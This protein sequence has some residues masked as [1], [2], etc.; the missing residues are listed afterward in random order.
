MRVFVTGAAGFI[1]SHIAE[2]FKKKGNDV[3]GLDAFTDFYDPH[4]KRK[5]AEILSAQGI[6][7]YEKNLVTD[8]LSDAVA[9]ADVI[10]HAAAQPGL[11]VKDP[12]IYEK[13]NVLGTERILEAALIAKPKLFLNLSSSSV[14]G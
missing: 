2:Y 11:S 12:A 1:G 7:I 3:A 14:Y 5:N 9:G 10:I 6:T 4:L 8:D 13:N